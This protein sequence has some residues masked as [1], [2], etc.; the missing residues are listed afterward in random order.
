[1]YD[2]SA[3]PIQGGPYLA[4]AFLCEK[5]LRE[6]DGVLS[7][8]RMV[9][10]W[11]VSGPTEA[12]PPTP[13]QATLVVILKSGIHRG[14]GHITITPVSPSDARMPPLRVP[15][16]FEGDEE[17]GVAV[18]LPMMF[19]AQEPGTYWFNVSIDGQSLSEIP[20]RVVYHWVVSEQT[21]P[22]NP[23]LPPPQ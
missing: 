4:A 21:N 14:Q 6:A 5:A 7:F 11:T 22:S 13:I 12:M 3:M 10:R 18:V 17:R 2:V 9:D 15:V 16:L 23:G 8:V 20:L 1:V 19:P